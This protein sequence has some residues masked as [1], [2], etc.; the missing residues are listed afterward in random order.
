MRGFKMESSGNDIRYRFECINMKQSVG[1]NSVKYGP[2]DD[3]GNGNTHHIDRFPVDCNSDGYVY[4]FQFEN[5]GNGNGRYRVNCCTVKSSWASSVSCY[6]GSTTP[7][8][9]GGNNDINFLD[10]HQAWCNSGY[11]LS[12][13]RFSN[14]NGY[15]KFQ[16]NYRCC[17][18]Y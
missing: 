1:S 5:L 17:K 11:A 14:V 15:T 8:D 10:R 4:G 6:Y 16:M 12:Y 7:S 2:D 13:F 3:H 9:N 18:L